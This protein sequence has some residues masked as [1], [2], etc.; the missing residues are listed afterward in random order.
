MDFAAIFLGLLPLFIFLVFSLNNRPIAGIYG[1]LAGF[2]LLI[3]YFYIRDGI[4]EEILLIEAAVLVLLAT[5]AI[6]FKNSRYIKFQPCVFEAGAGLVFLYFQVFD[7]P[8]FIKMIPKIVQFAPDYEELVS[9]PLI[10]KGL[11]N[12]SLYT[13][14]AMLLHSMMVGYAALNM[15]DVKWFVIRMLIYPMLGV[16]AIL[17][18][19]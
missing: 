11:T 18:Y 14:L 3:V 4:V 12:G 16:A 1:S 5:P 2:L 6:V 9:D 7:E 13:G 19:F 8:I 15:S 17:G 10:I